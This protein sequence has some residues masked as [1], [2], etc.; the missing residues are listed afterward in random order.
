MDVK[1]NKNFIDLLVSLNHGV[2]LSFNGVSLFLTPC[3][4]P[5]YSV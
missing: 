5:Y 3:I 4:T 1:L 2:S